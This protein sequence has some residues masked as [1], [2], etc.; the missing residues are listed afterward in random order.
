MEEEEN[1]SIDTD[2]KKLLQEQ[3]REEIRRERR[4]HDF[5]TVHRPVNTRAP[6]DYFIYC[7]LIPPNQ[8]EEILSDAKISDNP[9]VFDGIP[10][11]LDYGTHDSM[12]QIKY[13]RYG[14]G[15]ENGFE[16]L[17]I[18]RSFGGIKTPYNEISEE[19]RHFHNLFHNRET[20]EYIKIDDAGNEERIAI[21]KSDEVKIRLK[22]IRQFLAV[23]EMYLSILFEFN[24]Y[25]T[26]SLEELALNKKDPEFKR[27]GLMCW[28][29]D[30]LDTS[31]YRGLRSDSR[32]RGRKLIKPL[33]KFK[34]GFGD[35]AEEPKYVDFIIEVDQNGDE[36]NYTCDPTKLNHYGSNP[37]A[38]SDLTPVHFRKSVLNKYYNEPSKYTVADSMLKCALLWIIKIDNH[39]PDR[40]IVLLRD[41]CSLP[42]AEQQHWRTHNIPPEGGVSSTFYKRNVQG[43]WV[44]SDHPEHLFKHRYAHLQK[45]SEKY[46]GWQLLR[47][48][49]PG[50]Q[51]HLNVLRIPSTDEHSDFDDLVLSLTKILIDSL[52]EK[53]IKKLISL[54]QEQN[55]T[56]DQ[57]E[58]L[59]G[60]GW[61]EIA[62]NSCDVEGAADYI[63]FLRKLQNL[64][65]SGSA[66]LK[67]RNYKKIAKDFGIESKGLRE[68]FAGVLSKALDVLDYFIFLI[69]SRQIN[70]EIIAQNS[71]ERGYAILDEMVGFADF[72]PTDGSVN[73]DEAIYELDSKP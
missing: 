30:R 34:S 52:N 37:D 67:G 23:K 72:D 1:M 36:I 5:I 50:D 64:R 41:L 25:S 38:P 15:T 22:E 40:V 35:F 20:D 73:H 27:E 69:R 49:P 56:P 3:R 62:L 47:P 12:E 32:L 13:L 45:E 39:S 42:H 48:L 51:Y 21:V 55:L 46:L 58:N 43:E 2:R 57:K 16:P 60:I 29:Y 63:A 68:V 61:L 71:R 44:S 7:A 19:F 33:E 10:A 65:S 17:I 18:R 24:E 31:P 59:R 11:T 66:H 8:V 54:E 26:Y 6:M 70:R 53:E 9:E 4:P 28:R 14:Y